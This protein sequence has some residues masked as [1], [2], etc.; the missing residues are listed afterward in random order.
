MH[1]YE[2]KKKT[3]SPFCTAKKKNDARVFIS[4]FFLS[5]QILQPPDTG[6]VCKWS[7]KIE[8]KNCSKKVIREH[9]GFLFL[10]FSLFPASEIYMVH[11]VKVL[12]RKNKPEIE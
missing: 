9:D 3:L 1:L 7:G 2:A 8:I 12:G 4:S 5:P 11:L 6:V 10:F